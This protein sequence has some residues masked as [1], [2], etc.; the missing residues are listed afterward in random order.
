MEYLVPLELLELYDKFD[1]DLGLLDERWASADDR[2]RFSP[3]QMRTLGEYV[4]QTSM[5]ESGHLSPDFRSR[6][7]SRVVDLES[8]IDPEVIAI[9]GARRSESAR[10]LRPNE[11]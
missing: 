9:L 10:S 8:R 7:E 4:D 6:V 3:E 11:T 2:G 1:G 5:L